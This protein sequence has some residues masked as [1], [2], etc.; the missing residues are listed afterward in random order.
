MK[1]IRYVSSKTQITIIKQ[2]DGAREKKLQPNF[3]LTFYDT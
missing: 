1:Y 2:M 3:K